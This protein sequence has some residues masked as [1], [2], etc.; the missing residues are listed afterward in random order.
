MRF[1]IAALSFA[2]AAAAAFAS[3][4]PVAAAGFDAAMATVAGSG[5]LGYADGD[6][7]SATF[8]LPV[9]IAIGPHDAIYVADAGSQRIRIVQGGVVRTLAGG[10]SLLPGSFWVRGG[11]RDAKGG[12]AR[13]SF[14]AGLA[15]TAAGRVYVA[16]AD[17]H[18]IRAV[19][20]DGTVSTYSGTPSESAETNGA[21]EA[22][23]FKRPMGVALDP[24]GNLYVADQQ[25]GLREI[26]AHGN[27]TTVRADPG[28]GGVA[29]SPD[30]RG[31]LVTD[32]TGGMTLVLDGH[33]NTM[34]SSDALF[35]DANVLHPSNLSDVGHPFG[36]AMID[37]YRAIYTDAKN[38]GIRYVDF[39]TYTSKVLAGDREMDA[40]N[41]RSSFRD[42]PLEN[43]RV[44]NPLGLAL[45]KAGTLFVADSNNRRVRSV[46]PLNF[47][48]ATIASVSAFPPDIPKDGSKNVVIVG[49]SF[50]WAEC[51]WDDSWEGLL[52]KKLRSAG[53]R[54]TL[55][56]IQMNGAKQDADLDYII[57][58]LPDLP[59]VDRVI[60]FVNE[61]L[62]GT[63]APP[64]QPD[65]VA[66]LRE[67]RDALAKRHVAFFVA[68]VPGPYDAD[69]Q[70]LPFG[71]YLYAPI[72][73]PGGIV[74]AHL[75]ADVIAPFYE[76][77]VARTRESGVAYA[78]LLPYFLRVRRVDTRPLY[79]TS[80][81]HMSDYG[82][83][84]AADALFGALAPQ[85]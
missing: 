11:Y 72:E 48:Q 41:D 42:G 67:A 25:V 17:N 34:P 78:D 15:I 64:W 49:S 58:V 61:G 6:A 50:V 81:G 3:S 45:G 66:K 30:G 79:G 32:I 68:V 51:V 76:D 47:R 31:I 54:V 71:R 12:E 39:L 60:F 65:Y 5:A 23:R 36:V 85:L 7:K 1:P 4:A 44:A 8:I 52:E 29:I 20:S 18:C 57:T 63:D 16:D 69:W 28:I 75:G 9:G 83:T 74:P 38:G 27:V 56:P 19:E 35:S 55:F 43:A 59:N 70:E 24:S 40:T 22:A 84:V 73:F 2:V 10:G 21:R 53:K 77:I 46:G 80:E 13:F 37:A 26:D 62:I 82:R 33:A 14:P